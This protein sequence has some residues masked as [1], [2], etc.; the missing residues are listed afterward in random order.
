MSNEF[1]EATT[2]LRDKAW[3]S[4]KSSPAYEY[5]KAMD[6]ATVAAGGQSLLNN[7]KALSAAER[8]LPNPIRHWNINGGI[9]KLTQR[10]AATASLRERG[11]P[12]DVF[13]LLDAVKAKGIVFRGDDPLPS[14][15]SVMSKDDNFTTLRRGGKYYWW[16]TG[17]A[18]PPNWNE[19]GGV[20]L[21]APPPVSSMSSNQ[22]GGG[23]HDP[24]TT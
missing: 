3:E 7:E 24:A 5:F 19:T 15:R 9:K 18:V 13:Q 21:L 1:V 23:G 20:D 17:E 4:V 12:M 16:F 22:E 6:A 8:P 2:A 10:A 14:F 11:E